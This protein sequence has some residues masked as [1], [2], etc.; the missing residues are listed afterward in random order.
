MLHYAYKWFLLEI[1]AYIA[2][3]N[4]FRRQIFNAF[5]A[6]SIVLVCLFLLLLTRA[7]CIVKNWLKENDINDW[8]KTVLH[9]A[10]F[11]VFEDLYLFTICTPFFQVVLNTH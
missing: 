1:N 10:Y 6:I 11:I 3:L 4:E 9:G 5:T 8:L 2:A 7:V